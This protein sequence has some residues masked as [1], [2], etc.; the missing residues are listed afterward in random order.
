MDVNL[1]EDICLELSSWLPLSDIGRLAQ[2]SKAF[3][4]KWEP[5]MTATLASRQKLMHYGCSEGDTRAIDKAISCGYLPTY[6]DLEYA[7]E[8]IIKSNAAPFAESLVT[9]EPFRQLLTVFDPLAKPGNEPKTQLRAVRFSAVP[10]F[11]AATLMA[12]SGHPGILDMFLT[13]RLDINQQFS[14]KLWSY[15]YDQ[16]PGQMITPVWL[17]VLINVANRVQTGALSASEGLQYMFHH[18]AVIETTTQTPVQ[19]EQARPSLL[20]L[21]WKKNNGFELLLD[22]ELYAITRILVRKQAARG[23]VPAFLLRKEG[24]AMPTSMSAMLQMQMTQH[25][26]FVPS[27]EQKQTIIARWNAV[28]DLL[29]TPRNFELTF[30]EDLSCLLYYFLLGVMKKNADQ[31]FRE[32]VAHVPQLQMMAST[33]DMFISP[34]G[35]ADEMDPV[36]IRKLIEKGADINWRPTWSQFKGRTVMEAVCLLQ[37]EGPDLRAVPAQLDRQRSFANTLL[38][39]GAERVDESSENLGGRLGMNEFHREVF[40]YVQGSV[41][42]EQALLWCPSAGFL[43][44]YRPEAAGAN[45]AEAAA[46]A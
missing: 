22:D 31:D 41:P 25:A 34:P 29:L 1:Q 7:V 15:E 36:T 43:L 17:Y 20:E 18:G 24:T 37:V 5:Y 35:F 33:F 12:E 19:T 2:C 13:S 11:A 42:E 45:E 27:P 16:G 3:Y 28:L 38:G 32:A 30:Q 39:L 44:G 6:E 4:R 21:F 40:R 26:P 9:R 46:V 23:G 10:M 14:V 8:Y